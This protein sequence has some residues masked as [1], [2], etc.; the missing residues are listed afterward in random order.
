MASKLKQRARTPD[1]VQI[2]RQF[3]WVAPVL[4]TFRERPLPGS[5]VPKLNAGF[6]IFGTSRIG[7]V[8]YATLVSAVA[9]IELTH[10]KVPV[11]RWRHY[12]T[13]NYQHDD[14]ITQQVLTPGIVLSD[15][16]GFPFVGIAG[17]AVTT[18]DRPR[19]V[20][21]IVVPPLGFI[22]V[23]AGAMGAGSVLKLDVIWIEY[24]VGESAMNLT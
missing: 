14:A 16:S 12:M 9:A 8:Q 7:E 17:A 19:N 10:T 18:E 23:Q 3:G 1:E 2:M 13:M 5:Y 15:T 24:P 11:D 20:R 21:N 22:G 6:D 4:T